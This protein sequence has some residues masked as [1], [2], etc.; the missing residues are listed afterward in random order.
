MV[1]FFGSCCLFEIVYLFEEFKMI[2]CCGCKVMFNVCKVDGQ[3]VFD[4]DQVVID[5]LCE[6]SYELLCGVCYLEESGGVF[7]CGC[8]FCFDFS[9]GLVFDVDFS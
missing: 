2:C 3:F 1:V 6:V 8:W 5:G 4:G 9:Y 7:N